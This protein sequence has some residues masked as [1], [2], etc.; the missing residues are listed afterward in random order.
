M[1]EGLIS[2]ACTECPAMPGR[3]CDPLCPP[4]SEL[5]RF[6][7]EPLHVIHATRLVASVERGHVNRGQLIAQFAGGTLPAGLK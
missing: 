6:D 7:Q 4:P 3:W 5:V 1:A 2:R